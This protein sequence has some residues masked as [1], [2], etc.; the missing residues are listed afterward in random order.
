MR[1]PK[2]GLL[3]EKTLLI[4]SNAANIMIGMDLKIAASKKT[5]WGIL[6]FWHRGRIMEDDQFENGIK[7]S[8]MKLFIS[9]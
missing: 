6:K 2:R 1:M 9:V 3:Q 7:S 5:R 8:E 4:T